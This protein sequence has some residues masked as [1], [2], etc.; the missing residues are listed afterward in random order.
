MIIQRTMAANY[1]ED[2]KLYVVTPIINPQRYN[3]RYKLYKNFEK[4]INDSGAVLY[5][6]EAAFGNRPFQITTP[7][8]P[9][10]I[11]VRTNSELWHKENMINVAIQRLPSNW[12]YV[13][14]IDADVAFARPDWIDET[15]HQLQHHQFVQM[16]SHAVDLSP[17]HN[18]IQNHNGFVY[19]YLNK[20]KPNN[21][22]YSNWHP[23]FAWATTKNA[24]NSVGGLIEEAILGSAD[25][26]MAYALINKLD[27]IINKKLSKNYIRRIKKW[28]LL[29]QEHIKKN[30]GYVE[31]TLMH[32][33]HGKKKNRGYNWRNNILIEN[34]YDP[35]T[36]LKKDWQGMFSLTGNKIKLREDLRGYFK[37]RNEDSIDD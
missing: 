22:N 35:E 16:F 14:W 33:W 6:I 23:G 31:G 37:S 5:T 18:I 24:L 15:I 11:Q 30:I 36:D 32:Y 7:E 4:M 20:I 1:Q 13:A 3:S 8:N 9:Q 17:H 29:A 28:E 27:L 10:N 21:K 26:Y 12:E 34:N 2:A 19:S 25:S